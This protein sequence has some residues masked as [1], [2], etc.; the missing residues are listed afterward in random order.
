MVG[1]AN[2][3]PGPVPA[4]VA[5][6]A[7]LS[8]N[9]HVADSAKELANDTV[10]VLSET[11]LPSAQSAVAVAASMPDAKPGKDGQPHLTDTQL[12]RGSKDWNDH[13]REVGL[14]IMRTALLSQ[15][16]VADYEALVDFLDRE[17]AKK[18]MESLG[19]AMAAGIAGDWDNFAIHTAET[20]NRAGYFD[21]GYAVSKP[22]IRYDDSGE[23]LDATVTFT[24]EAT[25]DTVERVYDDAED[26]LDLA[27]TLSPENAVTLYQ[28]RLQADAAAHSARMAEVTAEAK[29]DATAE[30]ERNRPPTLREAFKDL[31]DLD[32]TGTGF[33][34]LPLEE[35]TAAAREYIAAFAAGAEPAGLPLPEPYRRPQ[36]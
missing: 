34:A 8:K 13:Y 33:K 1:A 35:Q 32:E 6:L 29:A 10:K 15:G 11:S 5:S 30:T 28:Q 17:D 18:G 2:A 9:P 27:M 22:A 25:G 36:R 4:A 3:A 21:D 24:D 31:A 7:D 16:R 20:Y 26:L 23:V 12:G 19:K 14:P